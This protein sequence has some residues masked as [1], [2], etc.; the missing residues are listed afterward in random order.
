MGPWDQNT[1]PKW[2][3]QRPDSHAIRG[4]ADGTRAATCGPR[5]E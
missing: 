5:G 3:A 4:D 1:L 2:E